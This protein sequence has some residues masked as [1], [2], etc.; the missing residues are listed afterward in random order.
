MGTL[1]A[2]VLLISFAAIFL[3]RMIRFLAF[4]RSLAHIPGPRRASWWTGSLLQLYDPEGWGFHEDLYRKCGGAAR[5]D[6]MFGDQ[7]LYVSDPLA[8]HHICIKD[9]DAYEETDK[10]LTIYRLIFGPSLLATLGD[11][12][13]RQRKLLN[14][15]FSLRHMRNLLSVFYPIAHKLCAVLEGEISKG[16]HYIDVMNWT[17]RA[18]L[19]YVGQGGLGYSFDALDESQTNEYSD[20]LKD[21]Q[22]LLFRL[23]L[24]L[25]ILP[26]AVKVGSSA[27]RRKVIAM[28]PWAPVKSLVKIVDT[29]ERHSK[30]ILQRK[31]VALM[32]GDKG[33]KAQIGNGK[34]VMSVLMRAHLTAYGTSALPESE[35]LAH[36]STI[37]V[38]GHDTTASA[39][40]RILHILS[41]HPEAQSRL[42]D[43]VT[44]ARKEYGDLD[45]DKLMAL[46]YLDAVC[47]ETM[48][49]DPPVAILDRIV[50]KDTVLPLLWPIKST[51]GK[52][53]REICLKKGTSIYISILGAN[54]SRAIW[55]DDADDWKP[56]RW[57]KPLPRSV[58]DAHLPGV[59]SQMMT[60]LG[61]PRACIGFKFSEIEMKMVLSMLLEKFVFEPGPEIYWQMGALYHPVVKDEGRHKVQAPLKVSLVDK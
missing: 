27:F 20:A 30:D 43:E 18:A 48:R 8:L 51:D 57:L 40:S 34:D 56:E 58:E 53:I 1:T 21:F 41:Q 45:Y 6:L 46:P 17:S 12:H 3:W 50:R 22:P 52:E 37:V 5:L 60:F 54:R 38:A 61:G 49:V 13:R 16:T 32:K 11:D 14:P 28:V 31:R 44:A 42:R 19:E 55:G 24:F 29:I 25:R 7:C 36:M 2:Q 35:L 47:R 10:F 33:L 9:Q 23:D 59:Y 26:E 4:R 15:A 39:V